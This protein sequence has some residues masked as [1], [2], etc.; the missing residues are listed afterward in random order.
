MTF[1]SGRPAAARKPQTG[2]TT[3]RALSVRFPPPGGKRAATS[4]HPAR[5]VTSGLE[6]AALILPGVS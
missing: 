2:G 6:F 5:V 1:A 3:A 4:P